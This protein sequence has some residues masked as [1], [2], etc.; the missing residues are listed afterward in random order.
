MPLVDLLHR[1]LHREAGADGALGVVLVGDRSAEHAHHVV[2]DVLVDRPA[3]ALDLL[4]EPAQRAVDERL[5]RLRVEALGDGR[6]AGEV[7]EQDRRLAPLLRK[8]LVGRGRAAAARGAPSSGVPHSMQNFAPGG[9][10]APHE[11]HAGRELRSAGHAEAGARGFSVPQFGQASPATSR[12]IRGRHARYVRIVTRCKRIGEPPG[13]RG[14]AD[15]A[16][17]HPGQPVRAPP[18]FRECSLCALAGQTAFSASS[19][20]FSTY[21]VVKSTLDARALPLGAA[22]FRATA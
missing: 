22:V 10:S 2:A 9:F 18:H 6:V 13:G 15:R 20:R 16:R 12:T 8:L 7:G 3:V 5:H 11:G 4:A 17:R 19:E 14:G 21:S 1:G